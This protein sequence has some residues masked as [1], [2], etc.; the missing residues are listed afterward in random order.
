MNEG[1]REKNSCQYNKVCKDCFQCSSSTINRIDSFQT[2]REIWRDRCAKSLARC[3][4]MLNAAA[5][6]QCG[7]R[8]T[9][10]TDMH[11]LLESN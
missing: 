9:L 3:V 4:T 7:T 5:H 10:E 1:G 11:D 8:S 6:R 2:V